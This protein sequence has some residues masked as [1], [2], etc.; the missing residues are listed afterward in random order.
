MEKAYVGVTGITTRE[1][2]AGAA[3]AFK[4]HCFNLEYSEHVPMM[5]FLVSYKT[6]EYG[7]NPGRQRYP[8][9]ADLPELL[10]AAKG[11]AFNT[12]H[13]NTRN[14][15]GFSA[16][17]SKVMECDKI[18]ERELVGGVQFNIA[19]PKPSELAKIRHRYPELKQ[20]IQL[21]ERATAGMT[22]S[23]IARTV[24]GKYAEPDYILIDP[25]GGKGVNFD[26]RY[27]AEVFR[28]LS[29]ETKARVGIAGGLSGDNAAERLSLLY[30]ALRTESFSVDAEGRLRTE[31][32]AL[33]M[34]RV[35]DYLRG[36]SMV[37]R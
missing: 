19:W 34:D 29:A 3:R 13:Y 23:E 26:V 22:A 37:L 30:D 4:D 27:V 21:S 1:E 32:D 18:Y 31:G 16:E 33:D 8:A 15:E 35:D 5:G 11:K 2:V 10:E 9:L 24:A 25:S 20:I 36:A 6:L 28:E 12:I 7:H 14:A 17:I